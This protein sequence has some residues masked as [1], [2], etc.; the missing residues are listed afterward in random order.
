MNT[1]VIK[2]NEKISERFLSQVTQRKVLQP[3]SLI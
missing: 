1:S 2:L 3:V